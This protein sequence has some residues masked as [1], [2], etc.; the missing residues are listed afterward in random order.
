MHRIMQKYVTS[1]NAFTVDNLTLLISSYSADVQMQ[2]SLHSVNSD[3]V[4]P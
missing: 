4:I 3:S 1:L 2:E